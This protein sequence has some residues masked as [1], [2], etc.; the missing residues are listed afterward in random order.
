MSEENGQPETNENKEAAQTSSRGFFMRLVLWHLVGLP[1]L[2]VLLAGGFFLYGKWKYEGAGPSEKS[3]VVMLPKGIGVRDIAGRLETAGAVEDE[4]IFRL[5]VRIEGVGK[6]LKAGEY[7]I[8]AGASMAS[9]VGILRAGKSIQH[10]ITL[11]EGLT[12]QQIMAIVEKNDVL[13]GKLP[14]TPPEGTLLPETYSFTRGTTRAEIVER[15]RKAHDKLIDKLWAKRADNLPFKTKEEAV[16]LASI[17]EK[18]T[19]LP[20]ERP[21]V[22]SVFVNRLERPM[23]LQSDPTII[24]GLVGGKGPLGRPLRRSEIAKAT[25]YNTYVIDGLPPTP[26]CNPGAAS[27]KAVLDPPDTDYLYFVADGSGGHVFSDTLAQHRRNVAK[28]RQV[29]R[30]RRQKKQ[31]N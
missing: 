20:D 5:G 28:W 29:E 24:Y 7:E 1:V 17:V 26:I 15:M 19:G 18:E 16:I 11:P 31:D 25:P 8:P 9:I 4:L 21:L 12:S 22:A 14:E 3:L 27:L 2:I 6:D 23:R 13:K 10:Q 30:E